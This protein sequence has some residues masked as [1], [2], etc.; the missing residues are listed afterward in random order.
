MGLKRGGFTL[1]ELGVVLVLLGIILA[2]ALPRYGGFLIRGTMRSELRRL[3]AMT[4]YLSNEASRTRTVHYLNFDVSKDRYWVTVDTGTSR[5]AKQNTHLSRVR[6]LPE[7][8]RIRDVMVYG[9]GKKSQ[10]AQRIAFYPRSENDE[11][12]VHL[13][14][15]EK[16]HPH[17]LH[18]K[19]YSGRTDIY[20]YYYKGYREKHHKAFM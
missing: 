14:D 7:N 2:I 15:Q 1:I 17:S 19:P 4:R 3:A 18:I 5:A 10:G 20:N 6:E 8:I 13:S 11:A 16:K 9:R 12:I